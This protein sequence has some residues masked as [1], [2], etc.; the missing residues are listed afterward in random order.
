MYR[1]RTSKPR[2]V[3]YERPLYL[4]NF[5]VILPSIEA[6]HPSKP[7]SAQY[8]AHIVFQ[9]LSFMDAYLGKESAK[10]YKLTKIPCKLFRS[11]E[12]QGSL[13]HILNVSLQYAQSLHW[14]KFDILRPDRLEHGYELLIHIKNMLV[15]V[16]SCRVIALNDQGLRL[17]VCAYRKSLWNFQKFSLKMFL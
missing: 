3:D 15:E 17:Y 2:E 11:F 9:L 4:D 13:H 14:G 7:I 12:S 1:K 16:S 8:L 5:S 10:P 6:L